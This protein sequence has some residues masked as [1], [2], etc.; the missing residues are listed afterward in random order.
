MNSEYNRHNTILLIIIVPGN[1]FTNLLYLAI[2]DIYKKNWK[3]RRVKFSGI[4]HLNINP[5]R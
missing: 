2:L 1:L 5:K 4:L 3:H